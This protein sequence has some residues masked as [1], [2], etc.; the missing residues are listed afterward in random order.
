M[1]RSILLETENKEGKT[2]L[3]QAIESGNLQMVTF[4]L[5]LGANANTA[6]LITKRTPLMV[7]LFNNNIQISNLLIDKGANLSARDCNCLTGLHHAVDSGIYENVE[8]C[9]NH[10]F[11]VN[12]RDNQGWTPLLRAGIKYFF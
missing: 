6:T 2:P 11:D 3:I 8:L 1:V 7:A 10:E 4:L 9:L 12:A 5:N